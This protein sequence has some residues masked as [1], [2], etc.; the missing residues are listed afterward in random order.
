MILDGF[1]FSINF[2]KDN[3]SQLL[4]IISLPFI[5]ELAINSISVFYLTNGSSFIGFISGLLTLLIQTWA[6][7]I[8]IF[9]IHNHQ[10]NRSI[11]D[12]SIYTLYKLPYIILWGLFVGLLVAL[13]I[14]L[15]VLPGIYIALRYSFYTFE[16]LL[17]QKKSSDSFKDAF[18]MTDG[19][20]IKIF[21]YFLPPLLIAIFIT[22]IIFSY[23]EIMIFSLLYNYLLII[24][25]TI[26]S[27]YLYNLI[28]S[29]FNGIESN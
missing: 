24:I 25:F 11:S 23:I 19:N 29:E 16:I 14:L 8:L 27:Y 28:N 20:T 9:Y 22:V 15:L 17:S 3:F 12:M 4:L 7:C 5:L 10:A 1:K 18:A 26:Y 6:Q 21:L 13:G 2:L